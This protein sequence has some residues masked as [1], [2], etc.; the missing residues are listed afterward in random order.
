MGASQQQV[1]LIIN[2][3]QKSMQQ[4]SP[5]PFHEAPSLCIYICI[6]QLVL[7][8]KHVL[9]IVYVTCADCTINTDAHA[10]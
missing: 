2:Q 4:C 5:Q 9:H 3:M 10:V 8:I 7:I 1:S 6:Q